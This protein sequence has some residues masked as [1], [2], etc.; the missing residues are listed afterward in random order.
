MAGWLGMTW[1]DYNAFELGRNIAPELME[2]MRVFMSKT[3]LED[4]W[5]YHFEGKR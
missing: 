2:K 4:A 1:Q 3:T 5:N